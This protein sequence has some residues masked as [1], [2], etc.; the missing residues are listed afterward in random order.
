MISPFYSDC[1]EESF[2]LPAKT[3]YDRLVCVFQMV[4]NLKQSP[5][6]LIDL[7]DI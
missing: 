3:R 2:P 6:R 5:T 7:P 1:K 4:Y